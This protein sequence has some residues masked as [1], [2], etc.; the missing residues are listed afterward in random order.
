MIP[1]GQVSGVRA[2]AMRT[3]TAFHPM[4]DLTWR[5]H[6]R[7]SLAANHSDSPAAICRSQRAMHGRTTGRRLD[8]PGRTAAGGLTC[9]PGLC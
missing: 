5:V 1:I 6:R 9:R 3:R 8:L 2:G 4:L 7:D